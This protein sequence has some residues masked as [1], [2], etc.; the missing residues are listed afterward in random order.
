MDMELR[1]MAVIA[2][3]VGVRVPI[4]STPVPN[5]IVDVLA[6]RYARGVAPSKPQ[7]SGD[8]MLSTSSRSASTARVDSSSQFAT[9]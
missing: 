3:L 1:D 8:Q 9:A 6:A 4:W 2:V 5:L 7:A